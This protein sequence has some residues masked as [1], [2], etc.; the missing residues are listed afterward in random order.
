[1]HVSF[2]ASFKVCKFP[3]PFSCHLRII[4]ELC[5]T[6]GGGGGWT[7]KAPLVGRIVQMADSSSLLMLVARA[8]L[9]ES[10]WLL[11]VS[12][13]GQCR[14]WGHMVLTRYTPSIQ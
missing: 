12:P 1:M 5:G 6:R 2:I 10:Y 14:L 13:P 8:V 9:G 3:A 4:R 7:N 11:C